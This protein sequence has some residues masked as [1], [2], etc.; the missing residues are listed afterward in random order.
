MIINIDEIKEREF[1]DEGLDYDNIDDEVKLSNATTLE[2]GL[3]GSI[4][5]DAGFVQPGYFESNPNFHGYAVSKYTFKNNKTSIDMSE[6]KDYN[7]LYNSGLLAG[8]DEDSNEVWLSKLINNKESKFNGYKLIHY[9][10]EKNFEKK[11][12]I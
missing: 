6:K 4:G 12:S 8:Y 1:P 3:E 5:K 7:M 10:S 11:L 9:S 2:I